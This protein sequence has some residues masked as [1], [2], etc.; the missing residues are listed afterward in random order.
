MSDD[1]RMALRSL[2]RRPAFT[3]VAVLTLALASAANA[4][5]LAVVYGVLFKPLPYQD[6]TRLVAV[7]PGRF[8]SN[9]DL[10]YLR[11]RIP[12]FSSL[13]AVAPGWTM[14]LTGAGDPVKVTVARVSGNLFQMLGVHASVGRTFTELE[15][16][17]G[18]DSVVVLSHKLWVQ[19]FGADPAI[20]GRVLRLEGKPF[21]VWG[22]L[23]PNFEV[24]GLKTDAYTP[25]A[26]D[27]SAWYH[28]L[29]FSLFVARLAPGVTLGRADRDYRAV[30]PAIRRDRNYPDAYGRNA[31]LQDLRSATVGDIRSSL[32]LLGAAVALILLIAGANV[33]TLLLTRAAG[34]GRE[35]AV[36]AAVGA[37]RA[38]VA[39]ELLFESALVAL[40]GGLVGVALARL[41]V[42]VLIA[43]LPKDTPRAAEIAVDPLVISVVLGVGTLVGLLFGVAPALAA[44]R[45]K[46][47]ALLRASTS[48]ESRESKRARALMV[49]AE[50]AL[51]VVLGIG[52]G[53]MLQTLWR[54]QQVNPGFQADRVLTLHVQPTDVGSRGSRTT[55][56]YYEL[57][58]ERLRALPGVISAGAVQHLPFSGYSWT[59]ALDI[60]GVDVPPGASRP[61][62]GLRIATPGYFKAI[63]QPLIAGRDLTSPDA[64]R[65]DAVIVNEAL[66][67]QHFGSASAALGRWLRTR[68]GG[69]QSV[70]MTVVG[71]VGDVRHDALTTEPAPEIYVSIGENSINAM[72]LAIRTGGDPA[73]IAP[74]V[75]EAIWSIDRNVPISDIQTMSAKVGTSLARPRLLMYLLTGF[76]MVGL[77]L[78]VV[79]VYGVVAYSV[80]Q[81]RREIGIMLALGAERDR[82]I[83]AVL[84]EGAM[85][86]LA[87]L[88]IGLPAAI[89]ASRLM[90]TVLFGVTP[91]DPVTFGLVAAIIGGIVLAACLLPAYRAAR[92]D[93]LT[94]LRSE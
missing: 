82:V 64:S 2:L 83:R 61:T 40:A 20:V 76:A 92:V 84:H 16:R 86:A 29:S 53:L 69:T 62:A 35:I 18:A 6:P 59:A 47:A 26:L 46:P 34:R 88:G 42:P 72:M 52:A 93:P 79:G 55:S 67:K 36:R 14:A 24:F 27:A 58:L 1:F 22:V 43:A 63:G 11:D 33:G 17:T 5:I 89:L 77:V 30:I 81:R 51:A 37:S 38:R 8:Q 44:A 73:A 94:A 91:S 74:A 32:V 87:G 31:R 75:R 28:Q 50:I 12:S 19:Q 57:V 4:A 9:A 54:M 45:F 78:A 85:Y 56:A 41:A 49:S 68:G 3:A 48:S 25:F 13:A 71:V 80:T 60:Q 23:P 21:E 10:I 7:W 65:K 90:R 15:A 39:R 66:A 70:W